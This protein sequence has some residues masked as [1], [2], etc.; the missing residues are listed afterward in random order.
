MDERRLDIAFS[1]ARNAGYLEYG[2]R[3][4]IEKSARKLPPLSEA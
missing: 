3:Q 1:M 2:V 4:I